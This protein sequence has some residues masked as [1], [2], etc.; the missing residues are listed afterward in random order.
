MELE[1]EKLLELFNYDPDTGAF[2]RLKTV[3]P[4]ALAGSTVG[5]KNTYGYL[6]VIISGKEYKLHRLAFLYMNGCFPKHQVDHINHDPSDNRWS[7]LRECTITQNQA[8]T[9]MR[10]NNTS[11]Y[12]GVSYNSECKKP[13]KAQIN[14][15]KK[16]TCLGHFKTPEEAHSAYK[17]A[18]INHYGDFANY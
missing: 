6:R 10:K 16:T 13:W 11:G 14:I 18:A 9:R 2:T 17:A 8:N 1:Q 4:N 7:N 15:D 3:G 5:S 12:K